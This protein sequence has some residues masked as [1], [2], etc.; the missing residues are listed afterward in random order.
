MRMA[1][2]LTP[3]ILRTFSLCK[4]ESAA[5]ASNEHT[6]TTYPNQAVAQIAQ[7]RTCAATP[8]HFDVNG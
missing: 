5:L 3:S 7:H 4:G 1:K 2:R 6:K 8:L